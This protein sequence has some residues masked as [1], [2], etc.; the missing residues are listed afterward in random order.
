M[1]IRAAFHDFFVYGARGE[2]RKG[3]K[4]ESIIIPVERGPADIHNLLGQGDVSSRV[5]QGLHGLIS[6]LTNAVLSVL[7]KRGR[8][9][10]T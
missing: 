5:V 9:A 8:L 4:N 3:R 2:A 10:T 1:R 6:P 7:L